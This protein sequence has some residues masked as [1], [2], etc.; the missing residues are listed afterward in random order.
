MMFFKTRTMARILA[1]Q[2][3]TK[4]AKAI[5]AHLLKQNPSDEALKA[6]RDTLDSKKPA[7]KDIDQAVAPPD[8]VPLYDHWIKTAFSYYSRSRT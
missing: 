2:G 5:Y 1:A 3:Q 6:E 8:L 4:K 7:A